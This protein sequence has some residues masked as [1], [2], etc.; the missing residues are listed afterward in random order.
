MAKTYKIY[1]QSGF[2]EEYDTLNALTFK[3]KKEAQLACKNGITLPSGRV[4]HYPQRCII[5]EETWKEWKGLTN[6]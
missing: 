6:K 2:A 4:M 5:T 3:G 1:I